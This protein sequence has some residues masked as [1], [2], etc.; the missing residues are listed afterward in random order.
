MKSHY[1]K[2][3]DRWSNTWTHEEWE[4]NFM[5]ANYRRTLP[6]NAFDLLLTWDDESSTVTIAYSVPEMTEEEKQKGYVAWSET[7][8]AVYVALKNN[9]NKSIHT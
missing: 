3:T 4:E 5:Q 6:E 1:D 7:D 9:Y 2:E 8:G